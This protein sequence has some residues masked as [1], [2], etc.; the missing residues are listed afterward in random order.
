MLMI[1]N[2]PMPNY[3]HGA[4]DDNF[5]IA[6]ALGGAAFWDIVRSAYALES[7]IPG[8]RDR[9]SVSALPA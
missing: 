4:G 3:Q 7:D 8:I 2:P 9:G 5:V 1:L 6:S